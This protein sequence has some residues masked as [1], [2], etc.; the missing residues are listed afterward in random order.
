MR[1]KNILLVGF[2]IIFFG[3]AF[4]QYKNSLPGR[5]TISV[6]TIGIKQIIV[7]DGKISQTALEVK[8]GTTAL[9]ILSST[10]TVVQKGDKENTFVTAI[11]GKMAI[12]T[13]KEFWSFYVNGKQAQVGAGSYFAK[14]NDTIE[15]KIETY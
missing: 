9:Q 2:L 12:E 15:W 6:Q 14:N 7:I 3:T 1:K 11:D 13:N 10:H 5:K 8:R 4:I